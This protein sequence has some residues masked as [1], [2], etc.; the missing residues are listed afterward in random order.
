[1]FADADLP[2]A[3]PVLVN[4][5]I[6]NAGQTCS[7]GSRVLVERSVYEPVIDQLSVRF[8]QLRAGPALHDLDLGPL[9]N[10]KQQQRV[11]DFLSDAQREGLNI[12]AQ[13]EVIDAA[14]GS[15]FYQ[16]AVLLRD[17]PAS[18]RLWQQE[19]FGPVLAVCPFDTEDEAIAL[20]NSTDYGLVA[21]VWTRDGARQFLSPIHL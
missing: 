21:G 1:M 5:I 6:Q 17:V 13:G 7:A 12:A 16:P 8:S 15:G 18:S 19:I 20:A 11:W 3:L 14:P 9:I 10:R 4:A 2:S